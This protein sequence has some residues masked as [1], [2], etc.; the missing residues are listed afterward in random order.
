MRATV[1]VE[2]ANDG[3][4]S[5]NRSTTDLG[6][7]HGRLHLGNQKVDELQSRKVKALKRSH[8]EDE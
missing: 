4:T 1:I 6:E 5:W 7:V 2:R 8:D 3:H